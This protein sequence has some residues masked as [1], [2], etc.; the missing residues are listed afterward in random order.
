MTI[1][2]AGIRKQQFISA[3]L[4]GESAKGAARRI[5]S[6]MNYFY[7]LRQRDPEFGQAWADAMGRTTDQRTALIRQ[8]NFGRPPARTRHGPPPP[9]GG[10]KRADPAYRTKFLEALAAGQS[11]TKAAE[12]A[13]LAYIT[14]YKWKTSDPE[15]AEQ[16]AIAV[17]Q[18]IDRLEDEAFRRGVDGYDD[19][20]RNGE[21]EVITSTRR[22]SDQL[23]ALMLRAKIGQ[24]KRDDASN[25]PAG[26]VIGTINVLSVPS[27]QY[28]TPEEIQQS[29]APFTTPVIQARPDSDDDEPA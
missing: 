21:G 2:S 29:L 5:G 19:V 23:L 8:R 12:T 22:Y 28:L 1:E 20:V 13:D 18:G 15:F 4:E 24:Y 25:Q 11:A 17:Q 26:N 7:R 16:W 3:L 27:G 10:G 6:P 9:G 14:V